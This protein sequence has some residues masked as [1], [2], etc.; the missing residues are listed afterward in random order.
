MLVTRQS[1]GS[2]L[3]RCTRRSLGSNTLTWYWSQGGSLCAGCWGWPKGRDRNGKCEVLP[4]NSSKRLS[5]ACSPVLLAILATTATARAGK[6]VTKDITSVKHLLLCVAGPWHD[7]Y[8]PIG[9]HSYWTSMLR[10]EQIKVIFCLPCS[11]WND[12][13]AVHFSMGL[14]PVPLVNVTRFQHCSIVQTWFAAIRVFCRD[15][16]E[17]ICV[18]FLHS[19]FWLMRSLV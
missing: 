18:P 19:H 6:G 11:I 7:V 17:C 8:T 3:C 10:Q 15:G 5:S 16:L 9:G 12:V 2:I 1:F 13:L 4:G 14:I